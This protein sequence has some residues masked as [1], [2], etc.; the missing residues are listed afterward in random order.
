MTDQT[1]SSMLERANSAVMTAGLCALLATP[2]LTY[3][4]PC[5]DRHLTCAQAFATAIDACGRDG[6][7]VE[8]AHHTYIRCLADAGCI[9]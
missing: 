2:A 4:D 1:W 5:I 9:E 6:A 3:A 8:Q 7:C